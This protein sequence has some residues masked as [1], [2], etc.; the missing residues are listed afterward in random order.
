MKFKLIFDDLIIKQLKLA[1]K[2]KQIKDLLSKI[3]DKIEEKG[4]E[5]GKLL[6]PKLSIFEIK[7]KH[8]PIRVYYKCN[9]S[10]N[11]IYIFEYEM[12]TSKEKQQKTIE[13][14]KKKI[15]KT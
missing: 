8:P 7:L 5:A 12:K 4:S 1:A 6:D 3:L 10:N 11:E 13:K 9:R 14:I 2:N 15:S